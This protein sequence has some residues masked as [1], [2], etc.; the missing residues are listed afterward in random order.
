MI[1]FFCRQISST[2]QNDYLR[3]IVQY[4]E[5]MPIPEIDARARHELEPRVRRLLDIVGQG[6]EAQRLED[7]VNQLVYR[8]F[9]LTAEEIGLIEEQVQRSR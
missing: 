8:L 4:M 1:G 7:E 6:P 3:F 9:D 5:Q 2:I